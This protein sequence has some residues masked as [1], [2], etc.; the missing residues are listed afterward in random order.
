MS[1]LTTKY[2]VNLR[3]G[4]Q[5]PAFPSLATNEVPPPA[6]AI[7]ILPPIGEAPTGAPPSPPNAAE[8]GMLLCFEKSTYQLFREH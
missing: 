1:V 3:L 8:Y 7:P 4:S 5:P 6:N 2:A